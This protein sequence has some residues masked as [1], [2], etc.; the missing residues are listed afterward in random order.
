MKHKFVIHIAWALCILVVGSAAICRPADAD[1]ANQGG[2]GSESVL[3]NGKPAQ[4]LGDGASA[5]GNAAGDASPNVMINGKPA[6]VNGTCPNGAAPT[7]SP[8]VFVNGKPAMFCE[9]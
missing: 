5:P 9:G 8:N 3:I 7:P 1:E 2:S 4:R 6:A